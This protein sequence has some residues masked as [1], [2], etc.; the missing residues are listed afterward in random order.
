[1]GM[2]AFT[3]RYIKFL[4]YLAVTVLI[5]VVSTTLFLRFDLTADNIYSISKASQHVVSTITE[6]LTIDVFFTRNLPAP[7]NN[8]ERYL[9]DLLEEY[10]NYANRYFNYR[11]YDVSPE[12]GDIGREAKENQALANNYG[13]HPVQI[14]AIE[15][16][17]VKFQRAYMGLVLI[18]GDL[19]ERI[20]TITSTDGL[21]YRLTMSMQ[22]LNNKISA[23]L[24]LKEN[25]KI[26]LILSSSLNKVASYMRLNNLPDLPDRME[27]IVKK[28]NE[29]H[30][31]KLEFKYLDP[32]KDASLWETVR[33]HKIMNLKWPALSGGRIEAGEG[34]IGLLMEHGEKV[35]SIPLIHVLKL[36]IIGTQ[37]QMTD[38]RELEQLVSENIES[39]LDINED[40]GYLT[41]HGTPDLFG[42]PPMGT[43]GRGNPD[44]LNNFQA[45]I[46]QNY[47]MKRVDLKNGPIPDSFN[48]LIIAGPTDHFTDYELFQIDQFLMKGKTLALFLDRFHEVNPSGQDATQPRNAQVPMIS[49]LDTGLEKLLNHYGVYIEKSYV[50]DE[51][52]Y[53]QRMRI[54]SGGGERAIYFAPL[55]KDQTINNDPGFMKNIKGLLLFKVSPLEINSKQ[56]EDLGLKK[57]RLFSSSE[58]S[59]EMAGRINLNPLFI[60][61]P[62]TPDQ[63]KSFPLAYI[64]EGRFTSYFSDKPMPEKDSGKPE[65][66][67]KKPDVGMEGGPGMDLSKIEGRG[68]VLKKGEPGKI[69][70]IA[71]SEVLKDSLLDREGKTPNAMF[72][73]NVIDYLNDRE[74]IAIM[75][76]KEQRFNPLRETG[77]GIRTFI[78]TFNIIGLPLLVVLF[79]LF[80]LFLRHARKKRIQIMFQ[81]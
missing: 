46:S 81:N 52:C 28:L 76:N 19:I 27:E 80:I 17:E 61:P 4:A 35:L 56:V 64:L 37:Y 9:H 63:F 72:I 54:R 43:A 22:K 6:P 59:W 71:T 49:P 40:L 47:T 14:Q 11:F 24:G 74:D 57:I 25:I 41:S 30:Y 2:K 16:D 73:M 66:E 39:L 42:P 68:Q 21:E 10:S 53:K 7:Y 70:L 78:K 29:T 48:C 15:K 67:D 1:M 18:H 32:S 51:S 79:G 3:E 50:M 55:I 34:A 45:L 12:E 69:F 20:P 8:T 33:K 77:A 65:D 44:V 23:L 62:S 60:R 31:G 58:R 38:P 5:N 36:P 26:T 75:R 13:I